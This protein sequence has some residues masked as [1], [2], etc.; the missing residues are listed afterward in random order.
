ME[1][2]NPRL[3][4]APQRRRYQGQQGLNGFF[5]LF[6]QEFQRCTIVRLLGQEYAAAPI[7]P[8]QAAPFD[9]AED[10]G[11]GLLPL[12]SAV[13]PIQAERSAEHGRIPLLKEFQPHRTVR[14]GLISARLCTP[15][16]MRQIAPPKQDRRGL[17]QEI[18]AF[19]QHDASGGSAVKLIVEAVQRQPVFP[20]PHERPRAVDGA[21]YGRDKCR[22]RMPQKEIDHQRYFIRQEDIVVHAPLQELPLRQMLERHKV[23]RL[24]PRVFVPHI[25]YA[26]IVP[27]F[28]HQGLRPVVRT[29]VADDDLD[30]R[31]DLCTRAL[32][33]L[34]KIFRAVIGRNHNADERRTKESAAAGSLHESGALRPVDRLQSLLPKGLRHTDIE[35]PALRERR[36]HLCAREIIEIADLRAPMRKVDRRTQEVK[37]SAFQAEREIEIRAAAALKRRIKSARLPKSRAAHKQGKMLEEEALRRI[38]QMLLHPESRILSLRRHTLRV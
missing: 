5:A 27:V 16:M 21:A 18:D 4:L 30:V 13:P 36:A 12:L 10:H 1:R 19:H 14:Y 31:I 23:L 28:P 25:A 24:G 17:P 11:I 8:D 37:P 22:R 38:A 29:V 33:R 34:A 3:I 9:A 32:Q 2:R 6:L 7:F 15:I 20:Q 26:Q 35:S